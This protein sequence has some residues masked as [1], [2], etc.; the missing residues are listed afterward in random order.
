[1]KFFC[2]NFEFKLGV[3]VAP[4]PIQGD[5]GHGL[6]QAKKGFYPLPFRAFFEDRDISVHTCAYPKTK[7]TQT[8]KTDTNQN[9]ELTKTKKILNHTKENKMT[10]THNKTTP[11][12]KKIIL[13]TTA[14]MI[15]SCSTTNTSNK[16]A[17]KLI[18]NNNVIINQIKKE[19]SNPKFKHNII[20]NYEFY[21]AERRLMLALIAIT[22][23]NNSLKK[24][25]TKRTS[26]E[27]ENESFRK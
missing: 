19:R 5:W 16:V 27:V 14:L 23:S 21:K 2:G 8:K 6:Q 12:L 18:E 26:K 13:L 1:M 7:N 24:Q 17:L 11:K 10:K 22:K 20:Y 9:K 4:R 25:F 15:T 3:V